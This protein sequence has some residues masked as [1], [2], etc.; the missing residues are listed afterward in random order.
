MVG[1]MPSETAALDDELYREIILDH[2]RRPRHR[3]EVADPTDRIEGVNPLCGDQVELSWRRD[4]NHFQDIGFTGRGCSISMA[5]ASML[6]EALNRA[7]IEEASGLAQRFRA[8]LVD[9]GP[10]AELGDLEA[11]AGVAD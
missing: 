5:S 11:F 4:R 3:G 1:I 6:C 2:Y 9:H 8:L 7:S 10:V